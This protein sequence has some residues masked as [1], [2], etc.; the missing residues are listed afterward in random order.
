MG[1]LWY[2]AQHYPHAPTPKP[3]LAWGRNGYVFN[4]KT[5]MSICAGCGG[6]G[7]L[8]HFLFPLENKDQ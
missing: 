2:S 6:W 1:C 7:L 4:V 5:E 3:H 8:S